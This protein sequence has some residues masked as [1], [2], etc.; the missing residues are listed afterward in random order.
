MHCRKLITITGFLLM[1]SSVF[2]QQRI[3]YEEA[4]TKSYELYEKGEWKTLLQ[5]GKE[6]LSQ[7]PDFILLRLRLGYAAFMLG[8]FSE[9]LKQYDAALKKDSYNETAHYYSWLCRKYLNQ[10]EQADAHL[11]YFSKEALQKEKLQPFA[12]TQIGTEISFKHTQLLPRG[13]GIYARIDLHTRLHPNI[14]MYHAVALYN[15]TIAEP[16]LLAV[17]NNN[18]IAINQKEYYN[19]TVVNLNKQW[20]LIGAYHYLYTPFNNYTYNNNIGL[21]GIKYNNYYFSIQADVVFGKMTDTSLQQFNAQLG[22]YPLGNLN[23]YSFST[24]SLRSRNGK[25]A[26]YFKQVIGAKI[27]KALWL[28]GN[29]TFGAFSN[30]MENDALYVYNA[31]DRNKF[32]AGAT[33]YISLGSRLTAQL[34]YTFEQRE[35]FQSTNTFNQHS[36]TGGISCKF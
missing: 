30:F 17:I 16:R 33:A 20:Q 12:V 9:A 27:M 4:N 14:N 26:F 1:G 6:Y 24:S 34:G 13:D 28:E 18:S 32:K 36:I 15:Q 8:N 29:A 7:Q 31:I 35:I 3:S 22:L 23:I 21:V 10:S 25:S 11:K 5:Y 19:K 2:A